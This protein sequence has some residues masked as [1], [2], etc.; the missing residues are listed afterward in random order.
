MEKDHP[1]EE[2]MMEESEQ[3][4]DSP[5]A[6]EKNFEEEISLL[7]NQLLRA[8]AEVENTQKRGHKEKEDTQKYAI[9]NFAR[10]LLV[11]SDT[12]DRALSSI[13]AEEREKEG[14]LKV[15]CDGLLLTQTELSKVFS[16]HKIEVVNPLHQNF[17]PALHQAVAQLED[18]NHASN[19]VLEVFQ[20]GYTLSGRLLRPAMVS[21]AK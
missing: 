16:R 14:F 18:G 19:T 17:D 4:E 8:L 15:L 12:L 11:I 9:T 21:V 6:P 3:A 7:R 13:P 1:L 10:D 20:K 2:N 5:Q